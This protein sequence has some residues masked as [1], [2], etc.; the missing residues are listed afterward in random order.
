MDNFTFSSRSESNLEGVHPDLIQVARRALELSPMD[1]GITEGLRSCTRQAQLFKSGK[2]QT[3]NS[4]HLTGHAIDIIAYP[5]PAGSWDF[6]DYE[7]IASAFKQ[8]A[9][10][11]NIAVEWGGDW[12]QFKDG[13]HFQLPYDVNPA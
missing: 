2:S 6:A 1:F 12:K 4:R 10:E 11:L 8:A 3:I 13:V 9:R 7:L 5:T